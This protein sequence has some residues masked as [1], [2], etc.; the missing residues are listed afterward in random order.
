MHTTSRQSR[1]APAMA[2]A[3]ILATLTA[4]PASARQDP[5]PPSVT[6]NHTGERDGFCPLARVATQLV[7]CDNLT[8]NGVTAPIWV[9]ER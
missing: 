7:R 4:V 5:G 9:P 6:V 8:G 3:L 1:W 2:G